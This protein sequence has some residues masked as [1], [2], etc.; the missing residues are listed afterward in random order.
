M[1]ICKDLAL[2]LGAGALAAYAVEKLR[3]VGIQAWRHDENSITVVFPRPPE[4]L[5]EKWVIAPK[6]KIGHIITLPPM[7]E[8]VIDEF[9]SDFVAALKA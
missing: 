8:T 4:S 1:V 9:V 3:S 2:C 6:K 5:R 7:N